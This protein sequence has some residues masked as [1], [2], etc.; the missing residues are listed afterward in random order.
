MAGTG[1]VFGAIGRE[2]G[3]TVAKGL[4]KMGSKTAAKVTPRA[5]VSTPK[6]PRPFT[7][8]VYP[9]PATITKTSGKQTVVKNPVR[10][11]GTKPEWTKAQA[12]AETMKQANM[13][14]KKLAANS[15]VIGNRRIKDIAGTSGV[16]GT[17]AYVAGKKNKNK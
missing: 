13:R 6:P 15:K 12:E 11:S 5:G 8:K 2:I 3:K 9:N 14:A 17:A 7:K 4:G 1:S 16:A 10:V